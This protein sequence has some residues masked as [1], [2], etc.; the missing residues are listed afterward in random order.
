MSRLAHTAIEDLAPLLAILDPAYPKD[1]VRIAECLFLVLCDRL[2]GDPAGHA[3][4]AL[5][6]AEL[7][8]AE[9][10]GSQLYLAKGLSFD[11]TMRD[12]QILAKFNG[13][14]HRELAHE[15]DVTERYLYDIV[16]RRLREEFQ[17]RQGRLPGLEA[18]DDDDEA[19]S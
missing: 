15:F 17:R 19:G 13:H 5:E 18:V 11:M 4:L 14:N 2:P 7:V 8:R 6:Q 9:L 1:L 10:G 16:A 12:R 3:Q